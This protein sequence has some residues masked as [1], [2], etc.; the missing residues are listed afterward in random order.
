MNK[1]DPSERQAHLSTII[2]SAL[3]RMDENKTRYHIFGHEFIVRD[4]IAQGAL[5][6]QGMKTVINEA[7]KASPEASLAWA[8]VCVILPLLTNPSVAEQ[9]NS[10]GF[11]YVTSR[12]RFYV[13]LEPLLSPKD[14]DWNAT[15]PK[16]LKDEFESHIVDL[17][18]RIL[19]FQFTSVVR[20]YRKWL[21]KLGKDVFRVEDWE[22]MLSGVKELEKIVDNDFTK[23]NDSASRKELEEA[24]EKAERSL[25]AMQGLLLVAGQQLQV[26]QEMRDILFP[27][28]DS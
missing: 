28:R 23:I 22:G 13:A 20:F 9:A 11:A 25:E 19:E 17:Y 14:K 5:L 2:K 27:R 12:M 21:A 10:N 7:V 8:G 18:Q 16:D 15:I 26:T 3:Q 1:L 4:Q 24:N 6:V